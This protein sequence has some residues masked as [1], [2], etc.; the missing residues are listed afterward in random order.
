M[1]QWRLCIDSGK[2][3]R[4]TDLKDVLCNILINKIKL[5]KDVLCR[6]WDSNS[7]N[8]LYLGIDEK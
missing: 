4:E 3:E 7:D 8:I 1:K 2:E 6:D 5:K